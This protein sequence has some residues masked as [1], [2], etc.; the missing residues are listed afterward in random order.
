LGDHYHNL[1]LHDLSLA[2]YQQA[3]A[4]KEKLSL[5]RYARAA[6][7]LINRG[8]Y[9]AGFKYLEDIEKTF[10][11]GYT[12]ADEREIRMLQAEVRLATG[13]RKDAENILEDLIQ[14]QPLDGEALLLS[15]RLAAE[16]LDYAKAALR[17]ERAAKI[18]D[19]EVDALIEH[20]RMLVSAKD[21][22]QASDLLERA[23]ALAPQPRVARYLQAINNINLS[24]R[25]SP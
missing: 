22:Q 25:K 16:N 13:K 5:S 15:A 6:K 9:G 19:F 14:K 1:G 10:G 11:K 4:K 24:A 3:L 12:D 2:A 7:V 20:A 8:S 17:F 21:Y 18:A 23:Q